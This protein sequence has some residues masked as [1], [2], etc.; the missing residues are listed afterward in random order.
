MAELNAPSGTMEDM[1]DLSGIEDMK[2]LNL[3]DEK[4]VDLVS[5]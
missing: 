4:G 3:K 1:D 5:V 2:G